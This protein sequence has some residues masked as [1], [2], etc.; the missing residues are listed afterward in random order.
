M[1]TTKQPTTHSFTALSPNTTLTN[2][3]QR[4]LNQIKQFTQ[5][6]LQQSEHAVF[7]LVGEAGTGKSVILNRFFAEMAPQMPQAAF[8]VNH[9]ELLKVYRQIAGVTP[10]LLK[11]YFQ[12][13]TSF[14]NQRQRLED[15]VVDL[16]VIDEAHLLLSKPDHYNNYY[17]DNQLADII[18]L[19]RVTVLVF[20]PAQVLRTKSYW[21]TARLKEVIGQQ[22]Q[23]WLTLT[24]QFRL[25]APEQLLTWFNQLVTGAE[26]KPLQLP[27]TNY[28]FRIFTDAQQ[29]RQVINAKNQAGGLAR[30]TATSGY[31]STL[32]GKK[33]Y[34]DEGDFHMPWDQYNFSAIPWAEQPQTLDEVGSIYTVQGFDLNYIGIITGP[35]YYLTDQHQL[36]VDPSR[37]TDSEIFKKRSD[38]VGAEFEASKITL[39]RNSLNVLLKRGVKGTYLYAHDPKLRDCLV[40]MVT[41]K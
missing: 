27:T 19:S 32:D 14:I 41:T 25:Q 16:T 9:P 33:H 12:R 7:V 3:Q 18:Q 24:K 11:K 4:T 6:S 26:I 36:G 8:L 40:K 35:P 38:L 20:D 30:V 28:D 39:L 37:S 5:N 1:T 23:Q 34:I 21:T 31:P 13:P 29:L 15:P 2:E 17:G 10:H 22:P